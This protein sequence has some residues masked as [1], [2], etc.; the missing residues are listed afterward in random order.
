M[1]K[2][3]Y[4]T[5]IPGLV[6]ERELN[7]LANLASLV[8]D[9]GSILEVGSC[10]GR[11][12]HALYTGKP[13][14]ASLT[15][16]DR[17]GPVA[18]LPCEWEGDQEILKHV[19]E[20]AKDDGR[21]GFEYCLGPEVIKNIEIIQKMTNQFTPTRPYDL[22]FIDGDHSYDNVRYEINLFNYEKTLILCDDANTVD[23]LSA[24]LHYQHERTLVI[25]SGPKMKFCALLPTNGYWKDLEYEVYKVLTE[26]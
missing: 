2:F 9:R 8:P 4:R 3:N 14:R 13:E 17:W 21:I 22:V 10:W 12:T 23:V 26:Q 24:A 5:D 11:S 25:P 1:K 19:M 20:I 16:I 7:V 15:V 6:Y 18:F